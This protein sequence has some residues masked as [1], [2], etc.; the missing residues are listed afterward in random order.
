[1]VLGMLSGCTRPAPPLPAN[2]QPGYLL[3]GKTCASVAGLNAQPVRVGQTLALKF[4]AE[5][6]C[7]QLQPGLNEPAYLL[8][9]PYSEDACA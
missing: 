3:G 8:K 5:S 7:L 6:R 2:L 9:L 4:G 1:M